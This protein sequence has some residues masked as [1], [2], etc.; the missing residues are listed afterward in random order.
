[1]NRGRSV[2]L[3]KLRDGCAVRWRPSRSVGLIL[4]VWQAGTG[5]R[6]QYGGALLSTHPHLCTSRE[7]RKAQLLSVTDSE[8]NVFPK[9][10]R[11]LWD[12][13]DP[14]EVFS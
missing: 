14:A 9:G 7:R 3:L 4:G 1:M 11:V 5:N 10:P 12:F 6:S 2:W 13:S 8:V